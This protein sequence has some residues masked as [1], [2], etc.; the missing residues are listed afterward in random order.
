MSE[1]AFQDA[2]TK[3]M[4][5]RGSVGRLLVNSKAK[6][7]DSKT[8]IGLPPGEK[9]E[10][11]IKSPIIMQGYIGDPK[12]TS[13]TLI[14]SGWLR[15][16]DLCYIDHQGYLLVADR[17]KEL[18]KYKGYQVTPSGLEQLL[19]SH[20]EIVDAAV[21]SYPDEEAG[22]LPMTFVSETSLKHFLQRTSN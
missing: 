12:M 14:P 3:E 18:I 9:G 20:P 10:L 16:S 5:H 1:A 17:M 8:V 13:E 7:R 21:I 15:T 2:T 11:L 19:Q 22:L 6:I 4:L